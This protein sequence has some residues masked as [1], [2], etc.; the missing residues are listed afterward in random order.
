[1]VIEDEL[2]IK[3][4]GDMTEIHVPIICHP[5]HALGKSE[6]KQKLSNREN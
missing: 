2:V 6:S 5:K 1:M 3:V 4:E